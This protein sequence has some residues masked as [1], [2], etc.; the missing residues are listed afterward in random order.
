MSNSLFSYYI[1]ISQRL[2]YIITTT[3]SPIFHYFYLSCGL[4]VR[5]SPLSHP[6][7]ATWARPKGV[8]RPGRRPGCSPSKPAKPVCFGYPPHRGGC[9][10]RMRR[11]G[12][13]PASVE[14]T[15]GAPNYFQRS[16]TYFSAV[17]LRRYI[18][19]KYNTQFVPLHCEGR[20]TI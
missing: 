17:R 8:R 11:P 5:L 12:R 18:S 3:C 15:S 1:Y 13:S 20:I 9:S 4:P 19:G 6:L 7:G 14:T 2:I 10:T 16:R